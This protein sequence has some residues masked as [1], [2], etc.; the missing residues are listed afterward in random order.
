MLQFSNPAKKGNHIL[1][2][3]MLRA[4]LLLALTHLGH[5]HQDS[6]SACNGMHVCTD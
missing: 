3:W 5:E 2:S 6:L 1:S 4:S